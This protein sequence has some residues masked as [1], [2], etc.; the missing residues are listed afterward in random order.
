M[1]PI[2]DIS[3]TNDMEIDATA[4]DDTVDSE[5][6]K[7]GFSEENRYLIPRYLDG[8]Q[9]G[10]V[11]GVLCNCD[12]CTPAGQGVWGDTRPE[13]ATMVEVGVEMECESVIAK[14]KHLRNVRKL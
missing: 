8:T 1:N 14:M 9:Y 2:D 11:N 4:R 7:S 13:P 10:I 12:Y 5:S 6:G 3:F